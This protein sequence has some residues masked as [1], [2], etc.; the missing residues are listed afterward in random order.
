M[1]LTSWT[2]TF[3]LY[4]NIVFVKLKIKRPFTI[5]TRFQVG[6]IATNNFKPKMYA[7]KYLSLSS[8]QKHCSKMTKYNKMTTY[9]FQI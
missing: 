8:F 1:P 5:S 6:I 7:K 3:T 9:D 4:I 2:P